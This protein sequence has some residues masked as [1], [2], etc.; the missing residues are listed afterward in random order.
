MPEYSYHAVDRHGQAADG[1][2]I[3]E[4]ESALERR[5]SDIGYWLIDAKILEAKKAQKKHSVPRRELIEFFNDA[6]SL[7]IAGISIAETFADIAEETEHSSLKFILEDIGLNIQAGNAVSDSFARY[8]NVFPTQICNLIRAG[9][10]GGNLVEVF[11]D[12]SLHLEWVERILSDVKQ[13]SIYPTMIIAAVIGLVGIMFA[14]VVPVF[15]DLFRELNIDMPPITRA[16]IGAGEFAQA[17][18]WM[19]LLGIGMAV[20]SYKNLIKHNDNFRFRVDQLKLRIPVLGQIFVLLAQSHFVHNLALMLKAGMPILDALKLCHGLA[21][22]MVMDKAIAETQDAVE[23]GDRMSEALRRHDIISSITLRMIVVG[24]ESGQ[25]D[26]TLQQAADRFDEE[27]PR[28]I[29]RVFA[30]LEPII[31]SVLLGIVG[32]VAGAIFLPMFSLM[33]GLGL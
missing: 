6:S 15:S 17:Y 25:L 27:I 4:S 3:A 32:L 9:E 12:I 22:N 21:D 31:T 10:Q 18:W 24:E 26:K 5:L 2:M 8:P 1:S 33:S 11:K 20:F 16:V 29:K 28:K 19:G 14:F 13:A 7:L 30:I 23:R